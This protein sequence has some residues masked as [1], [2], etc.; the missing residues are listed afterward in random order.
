MAP[1]VRPCTFGTFQLKKDIRIAVDMLRRYPAGYHIGPTG[2]IAPTSLLR[3]RS[4]KVCDKVNEKGLSLL[5][6][7]CN[8][9][10]YLELVRPFLTEMFL[11]RLFE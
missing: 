6:G 10:H 1:Q 3:M 5:K 2:R 8:T 11:A 7:K 9:S 4:L